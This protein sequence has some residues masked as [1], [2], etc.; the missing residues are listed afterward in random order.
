MKS[1]PSR[2]QYGS[3][4]HVWTGVAEFDAMVVAARRVLPLGTVTGGLEAVG[5]VGS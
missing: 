1:N 3:W 2:S 4:G 5:S